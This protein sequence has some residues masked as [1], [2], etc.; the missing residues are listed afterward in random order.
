MT[1]TSQKIKSRHSTVQGACPIL[2]SGSHALWRFIIILTLALLL[3]FTGCQAIPQKKPLT[4]VE[5]NQLRQEIILKFYR[6][7]RLK[8]DEQEYLNHGK[9]ENK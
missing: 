2:S 9:N 7:W 8:Q 1:I 5:K 3:F 4:D 6:A